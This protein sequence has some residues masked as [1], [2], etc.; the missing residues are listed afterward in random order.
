M[1]VRII[2]GDVLEVANTLEPKSIDCCVTSVPYWMLRSYL[3]KD[4]PLKP[5]EIGQEKTPAEYVKKILR[6]FSAIRPALADH[7]TVWLNVGDS[8]SSGGNGGG[9]SFMAQRGQTTWSHA[10][11]LT[12]FRT[13]KGIAN[14]NLCLIP[15]RLAIALQDDGWL[16]RSVVIWHKP[17]C[18]PQS[19]FG[20]H[21]SRHR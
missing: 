21:W 6:V 3:P 1:A 18:M 2:Q 4:H 17:A 14:G 16:V 11:K 20:W 13:T 7:A 12:G 5:L 9:G 8:Y 10:A 19:I 15:Q